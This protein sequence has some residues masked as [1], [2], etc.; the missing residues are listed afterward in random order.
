M[1]TNLITTAPIRKR[2]Y[3]KR[4]KPVPA[5]IVPKGPTPFLLRPRTAWYV[6][7]AS[8]FIHVLIPLT[9]CLIIASW[10]HH[11]PKSFAYTIGYGILTAVLGFSLF[12]GTMLYVTRDELPF[13]QRPA[14]QFEADPHPYVDNV[15]IPH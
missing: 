2:V 12:A 11:H 10:I 15:R 3:K 9:I 7:L 6:F 1:N 8:T 14:I 5:P 4:V 13:N